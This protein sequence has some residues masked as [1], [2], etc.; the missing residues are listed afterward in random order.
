MKKQFKIGDIVR[1]NTASWGFEVGDIGTV[2]LLS[3]AG[4]RYGPCIQGSQLV[5]QKVPM[6]LQADYLDIIT[7]KEPEFIFEI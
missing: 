5:K 1:I 6:W 2:I 4:P 3:D 7:N